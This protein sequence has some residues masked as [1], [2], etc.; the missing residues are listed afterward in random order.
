MPNIIEH[1]QFIRTHKGK[2]E[3]VYLKIR[4]SETKRIF[5]TSV[6]QSFLGS[7]SHITSHIEGINRIF[8]YFQYSSQV[9]QSPKLTHI[10]M[11]RTF[12]Y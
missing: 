8:K 12:K 5:G 3:N 2:I 9:Q 10:I 1:V 7:N 4:N 11:N 6:F